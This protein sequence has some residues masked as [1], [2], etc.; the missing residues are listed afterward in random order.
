MWD[1]YDL[2]YI[3][4]MIFRPYVCLALARHRLAHLEYE[5]RKTEDFYQRLISF[6]NKTIM[7]NRIAFLCVC[8]FFR[9]FLKLVLKSKCILFFSRSKVTQVLTE[10]KK[11]KYFKKMS[12]LTLDNI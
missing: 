12:E 4:H 2:P 10:N 6:Y 3:R 7:I 11:V 1:L 5:M 8:N 9:I